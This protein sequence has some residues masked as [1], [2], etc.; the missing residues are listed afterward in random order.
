MN[1]RLRVSAM[2][3]RNRKSRSLL[4]QT[5]GEDIGVGRRA[6]AGNRGDRTWSRNRA[7]FRTPDVVQRSKSTALGSREFF[8]KLQWWCFVWKRPGTRSGANGGEASI[9][10][11]RKRAMSI[12]SSGSAADAVGM[13]LSRERSELRRVFGWRFLTRCGGVLGPVS[14]VGATVVG[15]NRA[16]DVA[17]I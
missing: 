16:V 14:C 1:E 11:S 8:S 9:L 17:G 12:A 3:S 10:L 13:L 15:V 7:K 5:D 2:P 6:K 4:G